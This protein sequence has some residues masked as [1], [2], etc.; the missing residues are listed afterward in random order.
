LGGVGNV[1]SDIAITVGPIVAHCSSRTSGFVRVIQ[2][3][4][5]SLICG[6]TCLQSIAVGEITEYASVAEFVIDGGAH[7]CHSCI[8]GSCVGSGVGVKLS[9][10]CHQ[11]RN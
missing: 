4:S 10:G 8:L 5:A 1:L 7:A 9:V 6:D 3:R 2:S 11:L